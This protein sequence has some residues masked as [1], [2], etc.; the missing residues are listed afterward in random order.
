L[1]VGHELDR[2]DVGLSPDRRAEK[3]FGHLEP[4]AQAKLSTGMFSRHRTKWRD[5][6]DMA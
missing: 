5:A 3:A 4:D 2:A 6:C 1:P